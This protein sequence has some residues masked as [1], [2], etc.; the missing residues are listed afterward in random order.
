MQKESAD[1]TGYPALERPLS[2][3]ALSAHSKRTEYQLHSGLIYW[4]KTLEMNLHAQRI[5]R[6]RFSAFLKSCLQEE[7]RPWQLFREVHAFAWSI[8]A[9]VI[10]CR[11]SFWLIRDWTCLPPI[12]VCYGQYV[13]IYPKTDIRTS[14]SLTV[15]RVSWISWRWL[16]INEQPH[17]YP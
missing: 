3:S 5:I 17:S 2:P 15:I 1:A 6:A 9:S 12:P 8:R 14:E 11:K 13:A 7:S 4:L 10:V 16:Q